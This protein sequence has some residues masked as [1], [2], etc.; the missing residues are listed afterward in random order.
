[1]SENHKFKMHLRI[2][3]WEQS[4]YTSVHFANNLAETI[5]GNLALK[6]FLHA[7][8]LWAKKFA[9]SLAYDNLNKQPVETI[10]AVSCAILNFCDCSLWQK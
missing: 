8:L 4:H 6:D 7:V 10:T 1:M 3:I 5:V 9:H 2:I